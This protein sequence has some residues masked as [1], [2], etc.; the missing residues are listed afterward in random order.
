M[1]Y[2]L[3]CILLV[4]RSYLSLTCIQEEGNLTLSFVGKDI[5]GF[6]IMLW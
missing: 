5:K 3:N 4:R 6:V 2:Y 1:Q